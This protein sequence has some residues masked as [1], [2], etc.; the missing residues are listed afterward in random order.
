M[1]IYVVESIRQQTNVWGNDNGKIDTISKS[2]VATPYDLSL[3]LD[4]SQFNRYK[5]EVSGLIEDINQAIED[6]ATNGEIEALKNALE[7][8]KTTLTLEERI[9]TE[10]AVLTELH[11][12]LITSFEAAVAKEH[13]AIQSE[14]E[15]FKLLRDTK[16]IEKRLGPVTQKI[17]ELLVR[18]KSVQDKLNYLNQVDNRIQQYR[19][20]I[21]ATKQQI[22]TDFQQ[23][24]VF[25]KQVNGFTSKQ[26]E[27]TSQLQLLH[28]SWLSE[29]NARS[30]LEDR[31]LNAEKSIS[32]S[33]SDIV[34][35][36][37][38]L[39]DISSRLQ[40]Q[41]KHAQIIKP[42]VDTLILK[43]RQLKKWLIIASILFGFV[44]VMFILHTS[45][46]F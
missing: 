8:L 13:K 27:H 24:E 43:V 9:K 42:T 22:D 28:D 4:E 12:S 23:I 5:I 35:H 10:R 3:K 33:K 7:G 31:L 41:E 38:K 30:L 20:S 17:D 32:S 26:N 45:S 11:N 25:K 40:R 21:F 19:D 37:E 2:E 39:K 46:V 44:S 15:S 14:I 18:I 29:K 1:S 6:K 16:D 36:R 34:S